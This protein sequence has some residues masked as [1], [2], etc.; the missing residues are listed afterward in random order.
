[1]SSP[2]DAWNQPII[3]EFRANDGTVTS[4][5]FGRGLVLLHHIGAKTGT[6]RVTPVMGIPQGGDTWLVAASKAGAPDNP[7]WYHNLLAHP[8]MTIEVPGEGVVLVRAQELTGPERDE[9]WAQFTS[10]SPGF[11]DYEQRTTRI[12]PVIALHRRVEASG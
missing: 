2:Y 6:A 12:I 5:P 10:R 7:S 8:D 4:R 9:A 11:R 3:D 1:M